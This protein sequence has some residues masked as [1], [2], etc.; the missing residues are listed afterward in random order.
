MSRRQKNKITRRLLIIVALTFALTTFAQNVEVRFN[1]ANNT[2]TKTYKLKK[3]EAG[4]KLTIPKEAIGESIQSIDVIPSFMKANMGDPGYWIAPR[5]TY[6]LFNKE[7]GTFNGGRSVMPIYAMKKGSTIWWGHV[8]KWRFDFDFIVKATDGKY[9]TMLSFKPSEVRQFF[10]LYDDIEVIY[11]SKTGAGADYNAVAQ[12]YRNYQINSGAVKT[13][14]DRISSQPGLDYLCEAMVIRIQ[15][16][17]AKPIADDLPKEKCDFTPE[18]EYPLEVHMPFGVSE[19]FIQ[20][21]KNSGVDKATIVS[22]GW[23]YGGYDGRTPQHFPVEQA[24]GGE[25]GLKRLSQKARDIGFQFTLHATNTDGYTVSPMWD[26]DWAGKKKD[27][28]F[29]RG[30][31]WAGGWSINVCQMASWNKWAKD[32]LQKMA[33]LG[34]NGPHYIDVYSATYPNRCA[35]PHHPATP[36]KMAEYQ[37]KILA[38]AKSLMGG[39]AS[40]GAFDHVAGNIDYINYVGRDI[41]KIMKGDNRWQLCTGVFPLWELVYHGIIL[42]NSDRATQNHTRGKCL[43]KLE[44]SG[45]PRWM[46]G[47]GIEDP[48]I[49]LKI[50][51]FGG[52]P[53]FYTYKFADVPR[54]K[55]AWDEFVPVR[56]LQKELMTHH[57]TIADNVFMTTFEDGSRIVSNYNETTFNWKGNNIAPISYILIRPDNS[58]YTPEPFGKGTDKPASFQSSV[59]SIRNYGAV[60]DGK[61]LDTKAIQEAID[62]AA[63]AGGGTVE[64]PAGTYLCGSIW[65][66]DNIDL[67]LKAGAT[68]KGSPNINDYCAAD[69]CPQNNADINCGDY[70]SGGHLLLGVGIKN[71]TLRGPGCIDGNSNAFLLDSNGAG[72]A[73]KSLIPNRP[74]QMVWFVDSRDIRIKDIELANAPY[75]SCFVLNCDRVS[76]DGCNVHTHRKDYHTFNG[77]GLDIDRSTNVTISNCNIN[78]ADDCITLRASEADRLKKPQDCAYV[79]VTNCNLRSSCNAIRLGVGEGH[80]HDA[81]F[82]NITISD[83]KL[84]FNIVSSYSKGRRGTDID[85][86]LFNNIRVQANELMKIHHMRSNEGIIKNIVFDGI[87]GTA[88]ND[89]RIWAKKAVPFKDI[90]FR[91]VDVPAFFECINADVKVEGGSFAKRKLSPAE[92]NIRHDY[93]ENETKLLY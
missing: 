47:D 55:R 68:L 33:A 50:I 64:I 80:I 72:Y 10:D 8:L 90:V 54:I 24:A 61:T 34:V 43:Y 19:E 26:L 57:E 52:R 25:E 3:T 92:L 44:K 83:T 36:E 63:A 37:N 74:S 70:M 56:H 16:H 65:L 11:N 88:E 35:D 69:C 75:W 60:G 13:I 77:D 81:V 40:E 71:V 73:K 22:A 41:Q 31:K 9:E 89:S 76:I 17:C 82:S 21:I 14:K 48:K 66:K 58:I 1:S 45:D 78:T 28:T 53:I 30:G 93:I 42:Y 7:N 39:A 79:T 23:N 84:A 12:Y 62:D 49:A 15:T 91:N 4:L 18:T 85:G 6:G 86:I 27:G 46:E 59:Y 67:H 87:S 5:G 51:E 38:E 32:E 29:D 20:A 2:I